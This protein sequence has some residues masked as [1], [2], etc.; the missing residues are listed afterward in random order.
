MVM[1]T[2]P[3]QTLRSLLI[4]FFPSQPSHLVSAPL[5]SYYGP[6]IDTF[7]SERQILLYRQYARA[8]KITLQLHLAPFSLDVSPRRPTALP[9]A[10]CNELLPVTCSLGRSGDAVGMGM[11]V[12]SLPPPRVFCP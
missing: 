9:R 7:N 8:R 11:G 5:C 4:P 2:P 6:N 12:A 3:P 1:Q 10:A